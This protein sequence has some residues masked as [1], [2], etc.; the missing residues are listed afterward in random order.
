MAVMSIVLSMSIF[1]RVAE[2]PDELLHRVWERDDKNAAIED[3]VLVHPVVKGK[4]I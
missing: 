1:G 3:D 2:L 4:A